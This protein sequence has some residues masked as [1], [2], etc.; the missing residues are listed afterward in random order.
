MALKPANR[1]SRKDII[2]LREYLPTSHLAFSNALN[3]CAS[4]GR[5]HVIHTVGPVYSSR[6]VENR[7]SQLRSCY[8]TCLDR[9]VENSLRHIV[10]KPYF[11]N[12]HVAH[13]VV[14]NRLSR[15]F[16]QESTGTLSRTPRILPSTK[17]ATFAIRSSETRYL[18]L[19]MPPEMI[20]LFMAVQLDRIIFVVW[21]DKDK[22]VYE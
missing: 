11:M 8:K 6:D 2:C 19:T 21:S 4:F 5:K 20:L 7:A 15:L 10:R 18:G 12:L 16:R 17:S 22:G 14:F 9:V 1:K 13:L 3:S